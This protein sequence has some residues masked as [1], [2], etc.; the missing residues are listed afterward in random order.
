MLKFTLFPMSDQISFSCQFS[1]SFVLGNA[2]ATG[3]NTLSTVDTEQN[4]GA[5]MG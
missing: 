4:L 2:R 3:H 1:S 5:V